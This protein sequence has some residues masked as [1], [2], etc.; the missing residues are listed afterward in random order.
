MSMYMVKVY[1]KDPSTG[2]EKTF[3]CMERRDITIE[4]ALD[5]A[6]NMLPKF[7]DI[8]FTSGVTYIS[9][10]DNYLRIL[11]WLKRLRQTNTRP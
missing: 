6:R 3:D 8:S 9:D 7:E 5:K 4:Q 11:E 1:I 10:A 2:E